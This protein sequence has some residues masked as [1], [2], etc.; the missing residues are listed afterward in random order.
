VLFR[1][2]DIENDDRL[3]FIT[4]T[5]SIPHVVNGVTHLMIEANYSAETI[6]ADSRGWY[7]ARTE[8]QHL[9]LEQAVDFVRSMDKSC[10]REIHLIHLSETNAVADVCQRMMVECSGV[11]V[12]IA[13][14]R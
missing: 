10:L 13:K 12:H 4:D 2:D 14:K 1:S 3:L 11:P 7:N 8:S 5:C 6:Q 9:S